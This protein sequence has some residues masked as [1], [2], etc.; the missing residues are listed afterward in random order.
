M[1]NTPKGL[2]IIKHEFFQPITNEEC[3]SALPENWKSLDRQFISVAP[4]TL[5][6]ENLYE[7]DQ[8][9][10]AMN[11]RK[12]FIESVEPKLRANAG[13]KILYFGLAPI[14]L[15]IDL[16]YQFH[17]FRD[18]EVFQLHH[19]EKTW[20]QTSQHMATETF[21]LQVNGEL[22]PKQKG[23]KEVMLRLSISHR[24][25]SP[26][27]H[28]VIENAAEIDI[29][30]SQPNE[31][32]LDNKEKLNEIAETFKNVLDN[33]SD[34]ESMIPVIH[35]FASVPTGLAFLAGTKISPNIHPLIQTYQYDATKEPRY[36]KSVLI[37][38]E[39][40]SEVKWTDEEL[41]EG[42]RLR[43]LAANQLNTEIK[44]FLKKNKSDSR[45]R[46]WYLALI[47]ELDDKLMADKFWTSLP[48]ISDTTLKDDAI[49]IHSDA[50]TDGFAWKNNLWYLNNGFFVS[51][52]KRL[53]EDAKLQKAYRL[54]LFHEGLH[55]Y[56][57]KLTSSTVNNIGS[58]PKV[59][60]TAD[61]QADVYGLLNDYGFSLKAN[62][63]VS[64]V[65]QF[66]L[67]SIDVATETMWAFDDNGVNLEEIQIR[68]VNRYLMWYWQYVMI[69]KFGTDLN[70]IVKVLEDKPVIEINGL[71]TKE[72]NNRFYFDLN[73]KNAPH[74]EIAIFKNNEVYRH[75]SASN[76][77]IES[78]VEG[79]KK[80]NGDLIKELLRGFRDA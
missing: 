45:G 6:L 60:E 59:L 18:I 4:A 56:R 23:I 14:P 16:G 13:Y 44:D 3:I 64:P 73:N 52:G 61:Y 22:N 2:I 7:S 66:F 65:K 58:F 5:R 28:G 32:S 50:I 63:V 1:N 20:Y 49:D 53:V 79:F 40:R 9:Q 25:K 55:Y 70:E 76:L 75:G 51:L 8:V 42:M 19:I 17:N 31:D 69:E 27:T 46:A 54:F 62:L 37:K 80:M 35:L 41:V 12:F 39:A 48:P 74:L 47:P 24:V 29:E 72:L 26:D 11:Q 33:V 71:K 77:P 30:L 34:N 21:E 10:I 68:R 43:Q 38:G 36:T 67:D 15:A 57:H 78:L